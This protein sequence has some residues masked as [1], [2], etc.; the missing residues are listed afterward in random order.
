MH[1]LG[2]PDIFTTK[3]ALTRVRAVPRYSFSVE[4]LE[5][6]NTLRPTIGIRPSGLPWSMKAVKANEN[7]FGSSSSETR[8]PNRDLRSV[9]RSHEYIYTAP[10][11]DHM[12]FAEIQEFIE[13]L[14]PVKIK[15]IVSSLSS[16]IDPYYF[17]RHL[18]GTKP[19]FWRLHQK[20]DNE[21]KLE[22]VGTVDI[23]FTIP[24]TSSVAGRKRKKVQFVNRVSL[25]RKSGHGVRIADS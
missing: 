20:L 12:C 18:C 25:L 10:Y 2:F 21:E 23:K 11:S 6:L 3:T 5:C 8:E 24:G 7:V 9:E 15:G 16:N 22:K 17:F 14:R 1:L 13:L 4:T 19:A